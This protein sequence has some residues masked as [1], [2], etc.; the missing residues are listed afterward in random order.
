MC[1]AH[2]SEKRG[3]E[4]V[5]SQQEWDYKWDKTVMYY[6]ALN[7]PASLSLKKIRKALNFAMTTWDTEGDLDFHPVWF[8]KYRQFKAEITIE[9]KTSKQD[10]YFKDKPSVLA[11]AYLPGQGSVSGK[12]VFNADYIWGMTAGSITVKEAKKRGY[13]VVGNPADNIILR[14]YS[15]I[16]VLIHE[17]GHTLGLLH[18]DSGNAEGLDVMDAF[19]D[20]KRYDLSQRDIDRYHIKYEPEVYKEGHYKRMK[21]WLYRRV[22]RYKLI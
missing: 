4:F 19:Y 16:Q 8:R 21:K 22:R 11:Y 6:D 9:F 1:V 13:P 14:V 18:D 17:L 5:E 7:A 2:T 12:V 15:V 3:I 10:P 20:G